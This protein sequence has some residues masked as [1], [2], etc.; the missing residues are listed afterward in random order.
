MSPTP[1]DPAPRQ[2]VLLCEDEPIVALDLKFMLE[3]MGFDVVG[4]FA[5]VKS[6]KHSLDVGVPDIAVLDVNLRDG[7]VFPLADV[8]MQQGVPL[9][10]HSGHV[11]DR[12]ISRRYPGAETCM[13][14]VNPAKLKGALTMSAP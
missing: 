11:D 3:D 2:T 5:D 10:F 7:Q 9:I 13:K 12:E 6:A 1:K 4:P 8:L 14:P